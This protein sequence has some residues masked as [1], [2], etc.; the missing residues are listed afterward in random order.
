MSSEIDRILID[1]CTVKGKG[2]LP[3]PSGNYYSKEA[4][5]EFAQRTPKTLTSWQFFDRLE[6]HTE[7]Q[8]FYRH[9]KYKDTDGEE[10]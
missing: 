3:D 5:G 2:W 9:P 4:W 8:T 1:I 6:Q 7:C 10:A